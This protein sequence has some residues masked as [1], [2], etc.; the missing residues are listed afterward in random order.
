M[1]LALLAFRGGVDMGL[2]GLCA[3]PA[4]VFLPHASSIRYRRVQHELVE[5]G[6]A[7]GGGGGLSEA[8]RRCWARRSRLPS[9][10][11]SGAPSPRPRWAASLRAA[12]DEERDRWLA[13]VMA[14]LVVTV[15]CLAVGTPGSVVLG[16]DLLG[17]VALGW[18]TRRL[19]AARAGAA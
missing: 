18:A 10:A 7:L 19:L 6:R 1:L 17:V 11:P 2:V 4:G 12:A 14:T 8:A 15:G 13:W 9:T 5:E 3:L 16:V